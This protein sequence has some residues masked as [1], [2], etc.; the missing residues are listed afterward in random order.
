MSPFPRGLPGLLG[1]QL[2]LEGGFDLFCGGPEPRLA[3]FFASALAL[4]VVGKTGPR[5]NQASDDHVLLEPTQVVTFAGDAL[6]MPSN[7]RS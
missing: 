3:L 5:G 6:V 1:G 7:T 2:F 4:G